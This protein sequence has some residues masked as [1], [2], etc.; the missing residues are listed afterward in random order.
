MKSSRAFTLVELLIVIAIVGI[1][2]SLLFPAVSSA[3][4]SAKKTQAANDCTQ[5]ANAVVGFQTEYGYLPSSPSGDIT[6][7]VGGD[8][9]KALM[10]NTNSALGNPRGVVFIEG[11]TWKKG[12]GGVDS[13]TNYYTDPWATSSTDGSHAYKIILDGDY[14]N[15]ISNLP[16]SGVTGVSSIGKVVAVWEQTNATYTGVGSRLPAMS[17]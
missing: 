7:N 9:L 8:L 1:L 13:G 14:N 17:W 16:F 15:T 5:I 6:T 2:M 12:R 10:G 4:N 3:L 11:S